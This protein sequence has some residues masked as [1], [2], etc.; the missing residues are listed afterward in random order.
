MFH[1]EHKD[2]PTH[3]KMMFNSYDYKS[4]RYKKVAD[5]LDLN[6]SI[7]DRHEFRWMYTYQK[8]L[9]SGCMFDDLCG[10]PIL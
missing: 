2:F 8:L 6:W 1:P 9:A 5:Q 3:H 4:S 10:D 7:G